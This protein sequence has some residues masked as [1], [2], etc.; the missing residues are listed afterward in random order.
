MPP[1]YGFGTCPGCHQRRAIDSRGTMRSHDI[2]TRTGPG[3]RGCPG[4]HQHPVEVAGVVDAYTR[5]VAAALNDTI[6]RAQIRYLPLTPNELQQLARAAVDSLL[7]VLP[8]VTTEETE[9][10]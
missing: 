4:S 3:R 1:A 5:T 10:R 2:R 9:S 6:R 7:P 8:T